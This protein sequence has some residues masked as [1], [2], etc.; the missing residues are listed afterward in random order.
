L[1]DLPGLRGLS[2]RLA[3]DPRGAAFADTVSGLSATFLSHASRRGAKSCVYLYQLEDDSRTGCVGVDLSSDVAVRVAGAA[4]DLTEVARQAATCG[5]TVY[6]TDVGGLREP[7]IVRGGTLFDASSPGRILASVTGGGH[8]VSNTPGPALQAAVRESLHHYS[9]GYTRERAHDGRI[10]EI[11]VEVPGHPFLVVR[12]LSE[13][14][15]LDPRLLLAQQLT[16]PLQVLPDQGEIP[17][18]LDLSTWTLG[19]QVEVTVDASVPT[20]D[21]V[22]LP[23]GDGLAADLHLFVAVH[24]EDGQLVAIRETEERIAVPEREARRGGGR[25]GRRLTLRLPAEAHTVTVAVYDRTSGQS[26]LASGLVVPSA[27]AGHV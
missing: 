20:D 10:H 22:L 17:L 23:T 13:V 5:F 19:E 2:C 4:M 27:P 14:Y 8:F 9:I 16:A 25:V 3:A 12:H 11:D 6:A 24:G 15:D 21:L 1:L 26:G 7:G 18:R